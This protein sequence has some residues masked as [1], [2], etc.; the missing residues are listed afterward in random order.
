MNNQNSKSSQVANSW[1]TYWQGTGDVG[2][3]SSGGVNHPL[4]LAFWDDLFLHLKQQYQV[5]KIIDIASGNGAVLE[6]AK[7]A[8]D[9]QQADITCLDVSEAAIKNIR[10]R[11]PRV[12]GIVANARDIPLDSCGY[13]IAFSQFGVEYA[14]I[15]AISEV[16]RLLSDGGQLALMIHTREGSIHQEC[17]ESLDA[18]A[19]LQESRFIPYAIEMFDAGFKAVR[20]ANRAPYDEAAKKLASAI[21]SLEDIM[22]QYG[23]HV[24]GNTISRLYNDVGQIH[25]RIQHYEPDEILN[26]LNQMDRELDAYAGRMSSMHESA[27]DQQTFEQVCENL[28]EHGFSI[29]RAE[30]LRAPD[31]D[32]PLAWILVAKRITQQS[33]SIHR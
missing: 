8:F 3:Y 6:R 32:L 16:A 11:F 4:I 22:R 9:H 29:V 21:S 5:A 18:I 12:H 13:D 24:A 15:E 20:G 25:E 30:P 14:G 23:Q 28:R 1:D 7:A 26:W 31:Q 33:R 19:R 10:E 2:A 27:I 17:A